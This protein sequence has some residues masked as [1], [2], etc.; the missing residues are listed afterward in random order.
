V[1]AELAWYEDRL[2]KA[3]DLHTVARRVEERAPDGTGAVLW[4][5]LLSVVDAHASALMSDVDHERGG[6]RRFQL[7]EQ[8]MVLW[9]GPDFK[10][11]T[12]KPAVDL[13]PSLLHRAWHDLRGAARSAKKDPS[14]AAFAKLGTRIMDLRYGCETVALAEGGPARKVAKA[15][16]GLEAKLGDLRDACFTIDW[17]ED[18]AEARQDLI[19]PITQVL[20]AESEAAAVARRGWKRELKEVERRWR[21]WQG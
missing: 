9:D 19:D 7:T 4:D 20:V 21:K 12:H 6:A 18:L 2:G 13:L 16:R 3:G 17:L 1:R 10:A 8:M 15:A 11:K 14:D 5:R